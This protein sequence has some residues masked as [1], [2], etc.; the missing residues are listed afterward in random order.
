LPDN[1]RLIK[2]TAEGT[3][4]YLEVDNTKVKEMLIVSAFADFEASKEIFTFGAQPKRTEQSRLFDN[5]I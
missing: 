2:L 5:R 4:F 3:N 1:W